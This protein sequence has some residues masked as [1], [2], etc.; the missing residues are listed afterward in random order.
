MNVQVLH[1]VSKKLVVRSLRSSRWAVTRWQRSSTPYTYGCTYKKWTVFAFVL[2][3]L[4]CVWYYKIHDTDHVERVREI[5]KNSGSGCSL[6]SLDVVQLECLVE[7]HDGVVEIRVVVCYHAQLE[8]VVSCHNDKQ[9]PDSNMT[10]LLGTY[11]AVCCKCLKWNINTII[12]NNS[13]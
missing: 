10:E 9:L 8:T 7:P 3:H 12:K 13:K 11:I 1:C 6:V 5:V 2:K 4:I